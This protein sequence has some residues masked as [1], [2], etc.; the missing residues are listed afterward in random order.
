MIESIRIM[1][2]TIH[3]MAKPHLVADEE[4]RAVLETRTLRIFIDPN[5][6]G[7]EQAEVC[8]HEIFEMV[9]RD[10][11]ITIDHAGMQRYSSGLYAVLRDNPEVAAHIVAGRR[12]VPKP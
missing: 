2:K 6:D 9:A 1:G 11:G 12:I 3:I 7:Q 5:I 8:L 10:M 4:A